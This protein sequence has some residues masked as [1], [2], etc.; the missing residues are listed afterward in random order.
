M[1]LTAPD[2]GQDYYA[3]LAGGL[4]QDLLRSFT[5]PRPPLAERLEAGRALRRIAPRASHGNYQP[6]HDRPD[7]V[8]ML[9]QQNATRVQKL[10]PVRNARMLASP[11]AF[12]RGAAGIMAADL[13]GTPATGTL[14]AAC[15]DMHVGNF[16]LFASAERELIFA[17]NDFDEV[18]PGP[19]EWDLKR[20]AASATLA[21]RFLGD[22]RVGAEAA[23]REA[24]RAYRRHI[25]RYAKMGHLA[26][27]YDRI[28]AGAIL[29]AM[30]SEAQRRRARAVIDKARARGHLRTLDRMTEM[31]EGAP[32]IAE[33][34]PLIVR[35]QTLEDG[36]PIAQALDTMLHQYFG[37][38]QHDRK[39][40]LARYRIVD[41][42]RKVVGVGSVGTSCWV[43]FLQ[44]LDDDDPLF[45]QVKEARASVLAPHV[46]IGLP[47][48]NQGLRVVAGQRLIQGSPD[49][50]L[51]WGAHGAGHFFVR[52]LA[53]MKGGMR[54]NEGARD[55]LVGYRS[56]CALC[57]WA[58]AL[59]H[60]KSGD[61][62]LIAGYCGTSE[63]LDDALVAFARAYAAQTEADHD[64]LGHAARTGR[65]KVAA[66]A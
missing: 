4:P 53:D 64:A 6:R 29:A 12:M 18:H 49:I 48:S 9:E 46:R 50:F 19:W 57:G 28:D 42:A 38:L 40:L 20:L 55:S 24:V 7:P 52:Q 36:T 51:G 56:Y 33:D 25:R 41:V 54:F 8:A 35:E 61:P 58:L 13:A 47:V 26:V 30:P 17:I 34:I 2:L 22:D 39:R 3:A 59:A 63:A 10:V 45:L 31:V 66:S 14:V 21:A 11:F 65:V 60:A 44:G 62:A 43:I 27:W 1:E 32:R 37:S 16:G 15:G 5:A 23:T